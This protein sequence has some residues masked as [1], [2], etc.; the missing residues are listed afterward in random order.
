MDGTDAGQESPRLVSLNEGGGK[1]GKTETGLPRS[2][3]S[4][5]RRSAS[6]RAVRPTR[7]EGGRGRGGG[8]RGGRGR[9]EGGGRRDKGRAS[10]SFVIL[11]YRLSGSAQLRR[12]RPHPS[13]MDSSI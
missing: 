13:L 4:A 1:V 8:V 6:R 12:T 10:V 9:A 11:R 7:Q 3:R 5:L 2:R